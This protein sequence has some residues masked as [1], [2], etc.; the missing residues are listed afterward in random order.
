[1]AFEYVS[2]VVWPKSDQAGLRAVLRAR[3]YLPGWWREYA[4][5]YENSDNSLQRPYPPEEVVIFLL[6]LNPKPD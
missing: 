5:E 2:I 1:M 6:H 4:S 3:Q